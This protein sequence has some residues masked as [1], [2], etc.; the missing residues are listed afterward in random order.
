MNSQVENNLQ[1]RDSFA[2]SIHLR[3]RQEREL[4]SQENDFLDNEVT[5]QSIIE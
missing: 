4:Y 1:K 3:H 2:D 5:H